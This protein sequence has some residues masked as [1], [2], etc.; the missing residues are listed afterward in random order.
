MAL[1]FPLAIF[2]IRIGSK[3][4]QYH[5][6]WSMAARIRSSF[7]LPT[8]RMLGILPP[9]HLQQVP[10]LLDWVELTGVCGKEL[11]H[12]VKGDKLLSD[13][14]RVVD[15]EIVHYNVGL[16]VPALLLEVEDELEE[17]FGVV[18]AL[19][20]VGEDKTVLYTQNP[21]HTD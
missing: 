5:L 17:C 11:G 12:K 16:G 19:E 9:A 6:I 18:A 8:T 15:A 20:H 7:F 3:E 10:H 2:C 14:S 1:K 13:N 4:S 21:D